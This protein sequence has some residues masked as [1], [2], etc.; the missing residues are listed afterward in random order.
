MTVLGSWAAL[1]EAIPHSVIP[2]DD[3]VELFKSNHKRLK[4]RARE[5]DIEEISEVMEID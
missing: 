5:D 2:R 1:D 3:I 4:K